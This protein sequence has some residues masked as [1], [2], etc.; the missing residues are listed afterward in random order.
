MENRT[1]N[2]K[3][4]NARVGGLFYSLG[5][6]LPVLVMFLI[7]CVIGASGIENYEKKDWYLH[8]SFLI[9]PVCFLLIFLFFLRRGDVEK[10]E[11]FRRAKPIYFLI[12]TF[13]CVGLL[14]LSELNGLL[15]RFYKKAFGYQETELALPSVKG[16]GFL[17]S[18][19]TV[20]VLP[21]ITEE[22]FFRGAVLNGLKGLGRVGA[23]LSCGA[24]FALFHQNPAQTAYQFVCGTA[25]AFVA[26]QS[27]SIF[28]TVLTH[29]LNNFTVLC[30]YKY[31]VETLPVWFYLLSGACLVASFVLLVFSTKK[32]E[33]TQEKNEEK[34][35]KNDAKGNIGTFFLYASA[36]ILV[37]AVGYISA[38]F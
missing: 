35:E 20:C 16:A 19:F 2:F 17:R 34:D 3:R 1:E 25:F 29:F 32:S 28:P 37:C 24:L 23:C 12:A 26:L 6:L 7:L 18:V 22:L 13:L 4:T 5:N 11:T 31:G 21:A 8:L 38:F 27:G 30:F 36:G 9:T 10:R 15:I 14:S 33:Q